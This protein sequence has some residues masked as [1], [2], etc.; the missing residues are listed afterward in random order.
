M[1]IEEL[2]EEKVVKQQFVEA[3]IVQTNARKGNVVEAK[4]RPSI[5][6]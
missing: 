5:E 2:K 3:Q 1:F 6:V 4:V